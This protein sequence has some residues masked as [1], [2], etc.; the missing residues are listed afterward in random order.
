MKTQKN[1]A[2]QPLHKSSVLFLQLGL[3]LALIVSFASL[4]FTSVKTVAV[5][6]GDIPDNSKSLV[7]DIGKIDIQRPE[8][9]KTQIL[10]PDLKISQKP[11]PLSSPIIDQPVVQKPV[12]PNPN[13]AIGRI[14]EVVPP[15]DVKE[16]VDFVKIEQVPVFPGC[17]GLD[18]EQSKECF[19]KKINEFI[20][21]RFN[22]AIARESDL[23]GKL[24]IIS[25][26]TIDEKGHVTDI[27]IRAPHKKLENEAQRLIEALPIMEPG[28]QRLRPVSVL[29]TLPIRFEV[30]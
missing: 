13:N 30:Q 24:L 8:T 14:I 11:V 5:L 29:Y 26:F 18:N 20:V 2:N 28:R 23:S 12:N 21:K 22:T 10:S 3:L 15:E 4:E 27:I 17:E 25:T 19:N 9:P 16:K 7:P 6:S 1:P